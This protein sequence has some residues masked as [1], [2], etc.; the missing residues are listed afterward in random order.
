MAAFSLA[1]SG[2]APAGVT[3]SPKTRWNSVQGL[4]SGGSGW[5]EPAYANRSLTP[6]SFTAT[7]ISS[8]RNL[9]VAGSL[10]GPVMYW[11]TEMPLA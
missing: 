6:L 10:P 1:G 8:V 3:P 2:M 4:F 11:S 7:P 5:L 9:V